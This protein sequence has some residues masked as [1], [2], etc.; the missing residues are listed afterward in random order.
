MK[1]KSKHTALIE[2]I[3]EIATIG[4][5]RGLLHQYTEDYN[6]DGRSITINGEELINFGSCSYLGLETDRRVKDGAIDAI[7]RYGSQLACSRAFLS[8]TLYSEFE[9]LIRR[10]FD[11]PILIAPT[12]SVGHQ[13]VMPTVIEDNDAIILDQQAHWSMQDVAS[14]MQLRG[15][16]VIKVRHSR[17]D[18]LEAKIR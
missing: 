8:N 13:A 2:L 7:E 5:T 18:E 6:Y 10:I 1:K 4:K 14:K 12:T 16:T 15:I 9:E 3:Q 17:L 11:C